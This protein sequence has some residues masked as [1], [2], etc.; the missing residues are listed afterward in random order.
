MNALTAAYAERSGTEEGATANNTCRRCST[1]KG[2]C[3][4]V[5]GG[6]AGGKTGQASEQP[7][8]ATTVQVT[9]LGLRFPGDKSSASHR[10]NSYKLVEVAWSF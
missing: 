10:L 7:S 3:G 5:E 9:C 4:A 6:G 2:C 1:N 8:L